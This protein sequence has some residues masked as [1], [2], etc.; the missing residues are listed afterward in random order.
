MGS[1]P[2]ICEIKGCDGAAVR[3]I[4]TDVDSGTGMWICSDHDDERHRQNV[5]AYAP[6][7]NGGDNE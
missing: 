6:G 3:W 4:L 2:G 1:K 5:A 7:R